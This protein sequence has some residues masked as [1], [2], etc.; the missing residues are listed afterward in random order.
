M[1]VE[2]W[3]TVVRPLVVLPT[4]PTDTL[5]ARLDEATADTHANVPALTRR[6]PCI[7]EYLAICVKPN[8]AG[9][10]AAGEACTV[11][12]EIGVPGMTGR[13]DAQKLKRVGMSIRCSCW[14]DMP[15]R[16]ARRRRSLTPIH[17]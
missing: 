7:S 16:P 6:Q 11:Y 10:Y 3:R 12:V 4:V 13:A 15:Q 14:W 17:R 2:P 5:V 1:G 9:V 8:P